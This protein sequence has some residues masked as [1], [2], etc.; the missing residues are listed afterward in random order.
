M[1]EKISARDA[2]HLAGEGLKIGGEG[3]K[4]FYDKMLPAA[5]NKLG[6]KHGAK[7]GVGNLDVSGGKPTQYRDYD[8]YMTKGKGAPQPV[9]TLDIT[10]QLRDTALRKGFPLFAIGTGMMF[11]PVDHNPFAGEERRQ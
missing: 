1:S 2:G 11:M 4:G 5:A 6:K 10:P 8:E 7:M 9:H 3:M